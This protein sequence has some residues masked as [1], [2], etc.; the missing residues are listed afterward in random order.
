M[1][2]AIPR[3]DGKL[4]NSFKGK[5]V[6]IIGRFEEFKSSSIGVLNSLNNN[7]NVIIKIPNN[8]KFEI[9][10]YYEIT[11]KVND[12]L[13]IQ[14]LDSIVCGDT[15]NEKAVGELVKLNHQL[16]ELFY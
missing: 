8:L 14:A 11:G 4:L 1:S 3:I 10:K 5:I 7:G 16:P 6:R 2:E 13:Q 9:N 15:I 12:D